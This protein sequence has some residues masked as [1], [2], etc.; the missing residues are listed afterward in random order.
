[1]PQSILV[2]LNGLCMFAESRFGIPNKGCAMPRSVR[3]FALAALALAACSDDLGSG[4]QSVFDGV[5]YTARVV[6]YDVGIMKPIL[7]FAVFVTMTN[8]GAGQQTRTYPAACPVRL[9]LY[10]QTDGALMYDETRRSC[11]PQ[12]ATTITLAG[13]ETKELQSGIRYPSTIAGD[14]L[15]F[16]TYLV[17]AVLATEGSTLVT[18]PA[19]TYQ[20]KP[21][22]Q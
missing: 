4:T 6:T 12:P 21:Q 11:D 19:G 5:R 3:T 14:S 18:V 15:P 22:N 13:Q 9:R 7:V 10:R 20:L 8:T 17:R 2:D 16:T 1:M